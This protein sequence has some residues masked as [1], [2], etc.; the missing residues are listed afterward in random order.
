VTPGNFPAPRL[1]ERLV[2]ATRRGFV[3]GLLA[4]TACIAEGPQVVA[5]KLL[6]PAP[7]PAPPPT[8]RLALGPTEDLRPE[9]A[10][11]LTDV[12]HH[13]LASDRVLAIAKRHEESPQTVLD[14]IAS[15]PNRPT[16][17]RNTLV[18]KP[19]GKYPFDVVE[20]GGL[21]GLVRS[22]P[23]AWLGDLLTAQ[24]GLPVELLPP[25]PLEDRTFT[26]RTRGGDF[27][28]DVHS[29]LRDVRPD[30]PSHAYA[31]LVLV[32]VDMYASP[33]QQYA[34]G[35]S[36]HRG[37]LGVAS[38]ARFDPAFHGGQ[39]PDDLEQAIRHRAARLVSHEVA[40]MFGLEHCTYFRCLLGPVDVI[41]DLDSLAAHP[42]PVCQ[43][44]LLR[45][46]GVDPVRA[47][48]QTIAPLEQ[49]GL[50]ADADWASR[51]VTAII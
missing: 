47:A 45:G 38:F 2:R 27:Q 13:E 39:R 4:S 23:L 20:Q 8:W 18:I 33:E 35:W 11:W 44:K 49:L 31:M 16:E 6:A 10:A 50:V 9:H 7:A 42:C 26:S 43:C 48:K 21:V 12:G 5:P 40:H 25:E 22:P 37:R 3:G 28:L 15:A 46:G 24:F 36:M 34:F 19:L 14:F 1:V 51:R 41:D 17:E 32:N 29:L 30:L